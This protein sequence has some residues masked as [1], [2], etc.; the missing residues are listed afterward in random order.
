[1]ENATEKRIALITG[2]NR[3]IGFETARQ[4]GKLG[5]K[6]IIGARGKAIGEAAVAKLRGE[7]IDAEFVQLD[8]D[9]VSTY[10]PAFKLIESKFGRLDILINNAGVLLDEFVD[11]AAV[12]ASTTDAAI[13]R[14]T[15]DTNFF[16]TV[17]VTQK[18]LPL[19]RRSDSGRI[20][21]VSSLLASLSDHTNPDSEIYNMKLPAYDTSKSALNAYA[22]HLAHELRDT[23]IKVN[24][25]HP[26]SVI[27]DMNANGEIPVE[28][29]AR[30]SVELATL[31]PDGYSGRFIYQGEQLPW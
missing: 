31:P 26:G 29:G 1:M 20:V 17:A 11:G 8:I 22:V 4:L 28:E 21:F 24:I 10:E 27:T 19:V 5:N 16:N 12:Q 13:L 9:N 7:N 14:R 18:F 30:T 23:P 3:G 6:V 2:A 25:A 15:F